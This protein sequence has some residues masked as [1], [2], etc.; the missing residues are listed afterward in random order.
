MNLV[1][2]KLA[3]LD[4]GHGMARGAAISFAMRIAGAGLGFAMN[5][6][7]ARLFGAE[8]TGLF[9]LAI[10]VASIAALFGR[11]G[12]DNAVVKF[13]AAAAS[14]SDW[15][16]VNAISRRSLLLVLVSSVLTSVV[17]FLIS[18]FLAHVVFS[19]PA[20][21]DLLRVLSLSIFPISFIV[22]YGAM[23]KA[24]QRIRDSQIVEGVATPL[25]TLLL[26][27]GV[28]YRFGVMGAVVS[29]ILATVV[30]ASLGAFFWHKN[31]PEAHADS[32]KHPPLNLLRTSASFVWIQ[33]LNTV[34]DW[35]DVLI[36]GAFWP[37]EA[38]GIYGVA[39]RLAL[40]ASFVL[41]AVNNIAAPK[42]S[43]LHHQGDHNALARVARHSARLTLI[44][45]APILLA[46][47]FFSSFFLGIFGSGF[48]AGSTVLVVLALGQLVNVATGSVGQLL[49]MTGHEKVLR[50][51]FIVTTCLN[52]L[53]NYLLVPKLGMIGAA[54]ASTSSVVMSNIISVWFVKTKLGI[55]ANAFARVS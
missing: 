46:L 41:I 43:A 45:A 23:L 6:L 35:A 10:T 26:I 27:A 25:I 54:V 1:R 16:L 3:R 13:I 55:H 28:G 24:L 53:V 33:L 34:T 30:T 51:I 50:N 4:G 39:K 7:I 29:F 40:T 11:L 22:L 15:G 5:V 8:G 47:M 44:V 31:C 48:K 2:K 19:K 42:F 37:A 9:F 32:S 18:G 14:V 52:L 12:L 38:V 21:A 20:L 49:A 36:L 17:L